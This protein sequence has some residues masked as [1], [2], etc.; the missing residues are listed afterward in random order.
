M[1]FH[2]RKQ[3]RTERYF[4]YVFGWKQRK[5]HACNGSG[6]YDSHANGKTPKCGACSGT[7]KER[8]NPEKANQ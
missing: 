7:G 1:T 6:Y 8:Y 4:R 2:E 5:C 3:E